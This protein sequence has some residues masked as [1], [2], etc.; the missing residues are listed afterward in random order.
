MGPQSIDVATLAAVIATL[1]SMSCTWPQL[2]RVRRTGDIA[3]VSITAA[4]L[5]VSSELG[6]TLY[7][8]GQGLW[9]AVPEGMFTIA[10]NVLLVVAL[11]RCGAS[12][13]LSVV[14]A[15]SWLAVLLGASLVGGPQALAALLGFAYLIQLAPAVVEAWRTWKPSGIAAETWALRLIEAALWGAY[16]YASGDPPLIFLGILGM[17][18][19]TAI[20]VR[21]AVTR[22]RP[23]PTTAWIATPSPERHSCWMMRWWGRSVSVVRNPSPTTVKPLAT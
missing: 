12:G 20:L 22:N 14:A 9:A 2:A 13:R 21:V 4:A 6:W 18:E 5:T 19:S 23:G 11:T 3:G 1:L 7:L 16:G 15:V 17:A 8:G 10:A